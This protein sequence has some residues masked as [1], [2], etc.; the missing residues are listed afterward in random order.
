MKSRRGGGKRWVATVQTDSTHPPPGLFTKSSS[1]D[2]TR[3]SFKEGVAQGAGLR[4]EDADVFHQSSRSWIERLKA[5]RTG[6]SKAL[7][8]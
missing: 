3:V 6:K 4:H 1:N 8:L 2:R 5:L 7:A